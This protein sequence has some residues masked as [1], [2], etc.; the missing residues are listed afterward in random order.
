MVSGRSATALGSAVVILPRLIDVIDCR[1]PA[2]TYYIR[3]SCGLYDRG[4]TLPCSVCIPSSVRLLNMH[5]VSHSPV[6]DSAVAPRML[7]PSN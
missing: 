3:T 2:I 4:T 1:P 5:L 6:Y 7:L